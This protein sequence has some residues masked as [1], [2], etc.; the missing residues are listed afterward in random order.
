M[1]LIPTRLNYGS[2][3]LCGVPGHLLN[4]LQ[5]VLNAAARLVCHARKYDR[6][7]H[8]DR[9]R[10]WLWVPER[11]TTDWPCLSSAVVTTWRLRT[12]PVT[13]TGPTRQKRYIVYVPALA[14]D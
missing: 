4:R 12:S 13:C 11:Y 14:N 3:T 2:A 6:V 7:T 9:D 5:S 1:S 10:H 8:L